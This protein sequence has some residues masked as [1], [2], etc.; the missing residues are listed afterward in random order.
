MTASRAANTDP[1]YDILRSDYLHLRAIF[2]PRSIALI[3]AT[4]RPGS[5]GRTL[6]WNLLSHPF[7][8]TVYPVNAKKR[9]VLGIRAY[10]SIAE[11][12]DTVDLVIV[13][14]PAHTVPGVIREC[15][16]NGVRGAIVIS[17]GFREIGPDGV[18]LEDEIRQALHNSAMRVIGPNCLGVMSPRTGLNATFAGVMAQ[19]GMSPSS[20]RAARLVPPCWTGA[21]ARTWASATSRRSV[22]CW[23]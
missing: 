22:P 16:A 7:G 14:T 18:A 9:S 10:P 21:A 23:M 13:A 5:V 3:G 20:A 11:V 2:A 8:G 12:P 17:A 6:L 1:S 15:V 4:D 19:P